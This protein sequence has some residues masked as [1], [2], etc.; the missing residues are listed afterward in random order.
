MRSQAEE[1]LMSYSYYGGV[2][3]VK[4][5]RGWVPYLPRRASTEKGVSLRRQLLVHCLSYILAALST[6]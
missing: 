4:D 6:G 1:V 5:F 2:W 3:E